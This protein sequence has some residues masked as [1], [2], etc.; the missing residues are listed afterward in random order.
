LSFRQ[1]KNSPLIKI[2]FV[3]INIFE[4]PPLNI[5]QIVN[6]KKNKY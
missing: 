5:K 6:I 2:K 3:W 1:K 4:F